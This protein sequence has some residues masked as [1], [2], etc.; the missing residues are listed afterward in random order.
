MKTLSITLIL[1]A[2]L[3]AGGFSQVGIGKTNPMEILDVNGAIRI[4]N[5]ASVCDAAHRGAIKFVPGG[6]DNSD[7]VYVC[8]KLSNNL[9]AWDK[10]NFS[11]AENLTCDNF[12]RDNSTTIT[13][14]TE[15]LGNWT[16][17]SNRLQSEAAGSWQ[18][19]TV[20]GSTQANGCITARV[21]YPA[22]TAIKAAGLL[23]RYVSQ[24]V[25][26]M[27]KIQDNTASGHFD[28]YYIYSN[29]SIIANGSGLNFGTDAIIQFLYTGTS[30]TFKI[31]TNRDG[32]FDFTYT[33]T[34]TN[35]DLG[36]CGAYAYQQCYFDDW[37]YEPTSLPT[38]V[39]CDYFERANSSTVTGW[40]E[41]LG[42]WAIN[43][44]RLQSEALGSWQYITFDGSAQADGCINGRVIYQGVAAV[45]ATG[46]VARYTSTSVNILA[47]LQDNAG[48]GYFDSYYIYSNGGIVVYANGLNFGTD[49]NIQLS[50]TGTSVVFRID[51]NRNG[52]FDY[53]YNATV[54]NTSSGLCGLTAYQQCSFDNWCY[55]PTCP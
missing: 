5:S 8:R 52:T 1:L 55:G 9:Y 48:V 11:G 34:V 40:T 22:G 26:I 29:G 18:S 10:L 24:S 45:R 49:A 19:I 13:G 4:S 15:Q 27:A 37:C 36:L 21:T 6:T 2:L 14:W 33:V 23:A 43:T 32:T 53:T 44:N 38:G 28:S 35:T 42:N 39:T 7:A 31:D 41:Q 46:L 54:G 17:N 20:D 25:N 50:Y 12:N 47:K 3:T 30:V 16:I 51:T